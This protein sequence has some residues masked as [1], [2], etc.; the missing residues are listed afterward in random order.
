MTI[1]K[2]FLVSIIATT[3]VACSSDDDTTSI[4]PKGGAFN[5][6]IPNTYVVDRAGNST[7]SFSGQTTRLN[8]GSEILSDF[9]QVGETTLEELQS[10]FST[11]QGF[12]NADFNDTKN[13]QSKTAESVESSVDQAEIRRVFNSY[14]ENQVTLFLG[15]FSSND[16]VPVATRGVSGKVA[17]K[18]LVNE[19]GLELNQAFNK[20]LIG[21]LTL[22]QIVN[23]YLILIRGEVVQL[24]NDNDE[25]DADNSY[26]RLE[27]FWDEA[28]GYMYGASDVDVLDNPNSRH[29]E[30]VVDKFLY[31]YVQRVNND[32]DF[33]GI[34][35]DIFQAYKTGRAAIVGKNYEVA[36][37]QADIITQLLS[38]VVAIRAVFYL[39]QGAM[40]INTD[41]LDAINNENID[42]F[43]DLSEGYGFVYS[44]QFTRNPQTGLPYFTKSE[45]D[46][47]IA[48][49]DAADGFWTLANNTAEL[50]A[51]ATEI[52][53]RFNFTVAQAEA[54]TAAITQ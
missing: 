6:E 44:L 41:G 34:A 12:E 1:T 23:D 29:L 11:G 39:R 21:A 3:F 35:N 2:F 49:L 53:A 8:Q 16:E 18:R 46:A 9:T 54:T 33:A 43:H 22:D 15:N 24:A 36:E 28:Y 4:E 19:N 30:T 38:E 51:L 47:F 27:H 31:K 10:Q 40:K 20:G 32:V 14:I 13:I 25:L 37:A 7:V 5:F 42:A 26:T 45:V 52:A 17:G 50:D 48:R